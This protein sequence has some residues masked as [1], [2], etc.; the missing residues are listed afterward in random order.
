MSSLR[1]RQ[2]PKRHGHWQKGSMDNCDTA[3]RPN[4]SSGILHC[5]KEEL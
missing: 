5:G 3:V 4:W 1:Y 2:K